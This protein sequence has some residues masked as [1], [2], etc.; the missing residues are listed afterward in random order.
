L[1][2]SGTQDGIKR[3]G[4]TP[5]EPGFWQIVRSADRQIGKNGSEWRIATG[6]KAANGERRVANGKTAASS[7]WR[8]ANV[9]TVISGGQ[10]FLHC[11]K[12]RHYTLH[13]ALHTCNNRLK[14]MA[15]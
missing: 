2:E 12:I 10:C 14:P 9:E 8:L 6:K 15:W 7:E 5:A 11:Q 3:E 13:S 1:S 4:E